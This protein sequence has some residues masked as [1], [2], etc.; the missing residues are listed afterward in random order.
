MMTKVKTNKKNEAPKPCDICGTPASHKSKWGRFCDGC[1]KLFGFDKASKRR[2][3]VRKKMNRDS[4]DINSGGAL[5]AGDLSGLS[6]IWIYRDGN[7]LSLHPNRVF[8]EKGHYY[9]RWLNR[10]IMTYYLP[11]FIFGLGYYLFKL[12]C[13]PCHDRN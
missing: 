11:I 6:G 2:Q 10:N 13:S 5:Y 1:W 12:I 8:K 4:K 3:K 7:W 9:R